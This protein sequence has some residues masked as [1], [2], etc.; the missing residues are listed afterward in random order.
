MHTFHSPHKLRI[1]H[2]IKSYF[3]TAPY[4]DNISTIEISDHY[5]IFII[6]Q[7]NSI[8]EKKKRMFLISPF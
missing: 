5:I 3:M 4:D 6:A 7:I 2:E 1:C 8:R